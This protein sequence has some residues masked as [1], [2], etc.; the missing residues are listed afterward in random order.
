MLPKRKLHKMQHAIAEMQ[1]A[2]LK[3]HGILKC[4]SGRSQ[5]ATECKM[6]KRK[7]QSNAKCTKRKMQNVNCKLQKRA[8]QT[9]IALNTKP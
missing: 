4:G 3:Q 6:Q 9:N 2:K 7:T 8:I 1:K 5:N